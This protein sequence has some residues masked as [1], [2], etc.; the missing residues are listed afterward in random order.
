MENITLNPWTVHAH[1][2]TTYTAA[3]Y[4][5]RGI[6]SGPVVE[7]AGGYISATVYEIITGKFRDAEGWH[8]SVER[9]T[10]REVVLLESAGWEYDGCFATKR[11]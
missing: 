3:G 6:W 11:R 4:S 1:D 2:G 8:I 9:P 7:Y 10:D 5:Q